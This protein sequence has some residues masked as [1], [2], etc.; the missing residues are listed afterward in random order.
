MPLFSKSI[1]FENNKG[2]SF[3][4][5]LG[6]TYLARVYDIILDEKHPDY[7]QLGYSQAIGAIRYNLV[8]N[9]SYEENPRDLFVAYPLDA[10]IRT[11]PLKN[12]V[13]LIVEGPKEGVERSDAESKN[14]YTFVYSCW[15]SPNHNAI[16]YGESESNFEIDLGYK[17]NEIGS[18]PSIYPN[19]GDTI[20]QGR[21]GN[22]IRI[23]GYRGTYNPL[24]NEK[25]Q[26][27]PFVL[28][29]NGKQ[30]VNNESLHTYENI[31]SDDSSIYLTSDHKVKLA[32]ARTKNISAVEKNE[33]ASSYQGSQIILNSNRLFFNAKENDIILS[34]KESIAASARDVNIDGEEYISLDAKKIYLGHLSKDFDTQDKLPQPVIKG[35]DLEVFLDDL[36]NLLHELSKALTK[37]KTVDKKAILPLNSL[38]PVLKSGIK[39]LKQ[40]INPLKKTS[41]LKSKKVFTE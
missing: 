37:A 1:G 34:S 22:S 39:H 24:S 2:S 20:V 23:G 7:N 9:D 30:P 26:G 35:D 29:S 5:G 8:G 10:T 17:A 13:V 31:N 11:Y 4:S 27:K 32:E 14:Y 40:K 36:L 28:I 18:V 3:T 16:P 25:N 41:T 15:N 38:G 33:I 12:E 21:L 19:H 6:N